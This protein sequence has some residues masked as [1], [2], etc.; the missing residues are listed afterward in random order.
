MADF[1]A[2]WD[3]T[4]TAKA[5]TGVS[6]YQPLL[7]KSLDLVRRA[8]PEHTA[9]VI[10]I[11]GGASTL[12]DSLLQAGYIDVTI[13]DIS[14]AALARSQARMGKTANH[15]TWLI[16]DI[17]TW[18]PDR[19]WDVWHDRAVFHFLTEESTQ[20]RYIA[21]LRAATHV[22][23]TVI[24]STFAPDGP[25]RC[26]GLPVHRYSSERLAARIGD[27][28]TLVDQQGERH[29]TPS[30]SIQSFCYTILRRR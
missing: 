29:T 24:I 17:T 13:L 16:A 14:Q 30:G 19:T 15:V 26:S 22:G 18:T 1:K 12:P 9:S 2:H 28:F 4:Y 3:E 8:A 23:S 21:A 27:P 5:E 20:D 10:D 7:G 25:E 6:W 11:G